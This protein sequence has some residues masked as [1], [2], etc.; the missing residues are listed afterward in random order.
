MRSKGDKR[1][2]AENRSRNNGMK[3]E[4]SERRVNGW[5]NTGKEN[6]RS[7]VR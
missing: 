6:H 2:G 4:E 5:D 1:V 3:G 7:S